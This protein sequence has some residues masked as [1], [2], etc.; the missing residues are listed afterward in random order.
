MAKTT[1]IGSSNIYRFVTQR[2]VGLEEEL[3]DRIIMQNCTKI[4]LFNVKMDCL[5]DTDTRI[6]ISVIENF[7]SDAVGETEEIE[8]INR[9]VTGALSEFFEVVKMTASRL[10]T[11]KFVMVEPM[12]RPSL[13]WYTEALE[14]LAQDFKKRVGAMGLMNVDIIQ[15]TPTKEQEFDEYG[16]HLTAAAG[17]RF[18]EAIMYYAD[19]I[20]NVLETVDLEMDESV[21]QP[22][23]RH[24]GLRDESGPI[25]S[26][27]TA[28]PSRPAAERSIPEQLEDIREEMR[29]RQQIDSMR[30]HNDSMVLA[31]IREELDF[32]SNVKK[33][34]RIL[35]MGLSST[36]RRPEG[37]ADGKK[38]LND[39]VGAYLDKLIPG[40]SAMIQFVNQVRGVSGGQNMEVP[41]CEVRMK[42][43]EWALKL[44]REFG[45]QKKEGKIE[46]RSFV[47]N[48]VTLATKV[49]LEILR[50]V[51][52][53]CGNVREDMFAIGFNSRPVLQIRQK[54]GGAQVAFTFVDAIARMGARMVE[55]DFDA[56]YGRAGASFKGQMQQNF[57]VLKE[58]GV[59]EVGRVGGAGGRGNGRPTL[60]GGNKR[61]PE[62]DDLMGNLNKRPP[63]R[64]GRGGRGGN[65][66]GG[67]TPGHNK[68][69]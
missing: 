30:Q 17:K 40:S 50:A 22:N 67:G 51:G 55:S 69:D 5:K 35:V 47:A 63:G 32:I 33:E 15:A 16:V 13:K 62:E 56:A 46:G 65:G 28:G 12:A 61:G 34:D 68:I 11:S 54:T 53:K 24:S 42:E 57:V 18:V 48:V 19:E 37:F 2:D 39:I 23:P 44:R 41:T 59:R 66:R 29:K 36:I 58:S 45:K 38:W 14:I 20:F 21:A 43:R 49:R 26:V 4:D 7:L 9:R 25:A 10:P 52:R 27:S 3:K 6:I 31:R 64:G 8:I 60:T 1:I